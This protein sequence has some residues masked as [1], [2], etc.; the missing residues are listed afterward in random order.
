MV[1]SAVLALPTSPSA[2]SDGRG[3]ERLPDDT[4]AVPCL[5]ADDEDRTRGRIRS[6]SIRKDRVVM[7]CPRQESNLRPFA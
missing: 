7:W 6:R 5:D 4:S 2:T 1:G 3:A